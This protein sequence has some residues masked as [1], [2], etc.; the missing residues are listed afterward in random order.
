MCRRNIFKCNWMGDNENRK[1]LVEM[2]VDYIDWDE[3]RKN[4]GRW[5]INQLK[6]YHCRK[7]FD[8]ALGD[9]CDSIYLIKQGFDVTSNEVDE[10]FLK[11]EL[12]NAEREGVQ[13]KVL[14]LD[15]RK[16]TKKIPKESFDAV[17]CLGNSLTCLFGRKNQI[18][19]LREFHAIIK[20]RGILIIDE[21]NY[22]FILDNREKILKGIYR[23]HGRHLYYGKYVYSRPVLIKQNIIKFEIFNER[24]KK[25]AYFI[26]YPFKRG[27]LRNLL[28]KVGFQKIEKYSD[29]QLGDNPDAHFYTYVCLR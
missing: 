7:I 6:K 24:T 13:L 14:S 18:A 3:R 25:K 22:Q 23:P 29:C 12:E 4:E 2:W 9:G 15:W 1:I 19:A 5:L 11:K 20:N 26:V 21:R 10:F 16:L 27:E 8:A 28:S 17:L